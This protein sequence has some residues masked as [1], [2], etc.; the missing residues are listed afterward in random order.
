MI[1]TKN[2]HSEQNK[3]LAWQIVCSVLVVIIAGLIAWY[4]FSPSRD[5]SA[6]KNISFNVHEADNNKLQ[7]ISKN[8]VI[9]VNI[10]KAPTPLVDSLTKLNQSCKKRSSPVYIIETADT[11]LAKVQYGCSFYDHMEY[12]P[13]DVS[14]VDGTWKILEVSNA[15]FDEG[16]PLCSYLV[17]HG[18]N[19][20]VTEP[21]C[22][23]GD[24]PVNN[25]HPY[26]FDLRFNPLA[27]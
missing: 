1:K 15:F 16:I 24:K 2:A 4:F 27:K 22:V 14:K 21:M 25:T 19:S 23:N 18:I 9:V 10:A 13:L 20:K 12:E 8:G 3:L 17:D 26:S 11:K 6:A 7:V 5:V